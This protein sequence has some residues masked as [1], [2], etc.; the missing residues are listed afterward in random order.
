MIWKSRLDA[1]FNNVPFYKKNITVKTERQI[2]PRDK[3][4]EIHDL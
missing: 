2:R 4:W 1:E 3:Y